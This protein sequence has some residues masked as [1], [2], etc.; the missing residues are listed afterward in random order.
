MNGGRG[1][2]S[3][4]ARGGNILLSTY[5]GV[6]VLYQDAGGGGGYSDIWFSG[7]RLPLYLLNG[8]AGAA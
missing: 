6:I 8:V 3:H 1:A 7:L 2:P 4:N 5:N